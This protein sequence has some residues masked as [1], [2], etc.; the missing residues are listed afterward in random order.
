M[1]GKGSF[2]CYARSGREARGC[3]AAAASRT[4]QAFLTAS[5]AGNVKKAM[6]LL[7]NPLTGIKTDPPL[8]EAMEESGRLTGAL[9]SALLL[10]GRALPP[11]GGEFSDR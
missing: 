4:A 6:A 8:R 1:A 7:D 10:R 11:K 5:S 2:R 3:H 9:K